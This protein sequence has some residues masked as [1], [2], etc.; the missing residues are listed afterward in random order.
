MR[1]AMPVVEQ[2]H[3][4]RAMKK[5]RLFVPES[6]NNGELVA[7]EV[8]HALENMVT[9]AFGGCTLH[10][11][12]LGT[13]ANEAGIRYRDPIRLV[14]VEAEDSPALQ[15]ALMAIIQFICDRWQQ[16]AV[17]LTIA[18][19]SVLSVQRRELLPLA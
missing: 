7:A 2:P 13:W 9:D 16:E 1:N 4:P 17:F 11:N 3:S 10:A 12:L 19:V 14:E 6:F 5:I 8:F 18:D 15:P